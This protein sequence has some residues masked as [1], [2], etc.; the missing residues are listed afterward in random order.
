MPVSATLAANDTIARRRAAGLPVVPLG[1]GEAGLPVHPL[2]SQALADA[3]GHG[4]YGPVAGIP[5]LL[6]AAAGYWSRRGLPTEPSQVVAGPGSKPLL[7]AILGT[8]RGGVVLPKPSWVSYAAQAAMHGRDI[9]RIQSI[10]GV[11]DPAELDAVA[12][13]LRL[14]TVIVTLPD[15]P[16]GLLASPSVIQDLCAV[17]ER[18]DLLI[19]SDEIYRDLVIGDFL[20]PASVSP[21]RVVV[22]SG[23]SK[24][25][26]LGGWR[27]GIARFPDAALRAQ[28]IDLASEVWS[29]PAH[30]VQVA[31]SLALSEP[32]ALAER[33]TQS[34]LL[35][36]RVASAVAEL[37]G[38]PPPDG[39]FYL[40]PSVAGFANDRA[41]A[42]HLLSRNGVVVLPGSSF[43]DDPEACRIRVA[44]SQLYG[45]T[46][47]EREQ[48]LDSD[49]PV[50][51]PWIAA[52]LD[53]IREALQ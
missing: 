35:H 51:L 47:A 14:S 24:S 25:L 22:T 15:N 44:T 11:P 16:T 41:V 30:P 34:R 28:V 8:R 4:A 7:W 42:D 5:P 2:L 43:G 50:A 53:L 18:H 19:I 12:Q 26:A 10:G 27:L 17:A 23:L 38:C 52:Q 20:S 31:A 32:P 9:V 45:G 3:A 46:D 6:A 39:A 36:H 21:D 33:V 40:Y 37:F 13:G 29:A 1:F 49:D 48:A